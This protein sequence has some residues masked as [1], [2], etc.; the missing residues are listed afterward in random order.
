MTVTTI[1]V[2]RP[3]DLHHIELKGE[4]REA[5]AIARAK[6]IIKAQTRIDHTERGYL[7]SC[8][9]NGNYTI[10]TSTEI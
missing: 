4:V 6:H 9:N 3:D 2:G 8:L 1:Q 5:E 10:N 7:I